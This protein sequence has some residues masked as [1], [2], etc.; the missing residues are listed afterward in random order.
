MARTASK[1][2]KASKNVKPKAPK[3]PKE[4][5]IKVHDP[6]KYNAGPAQNHFFH[7]QVFVVVSNET[8]ERYAKVTGAQPTTNRNNP[9]YRQGAEFAKRL[10]TP[11]YANEVLVLDI[12]RTAVVAD[13]DGGPA[14]NRVV[15][16]ITG[17]AH[18]VLASITNFMVYIKKHT[19]AGQDKSDEVLIR[20]SKAAALEMLRDP[21]ITVAKSYLDD[22][23][24][25]AQ[26]LEILNEYRK[27]AESYKERNIFPYD[28]EMLNSIRVS[29]KSSSELSK[30]DKKPKNKPAASSV[31]VEG[32]KKRGPVPLLAKIKNGLNADKTKAV[33]LVK[34]GVRVGADGKTKSVTWV[35]ADKTVVHPKLVVDG[36]TWIVS[37]DRDL[38]AFFEQ[39]ANENPEGSTNY[40]V[41]VRLTKA[42]QSAWDE[43]QRAHSVTVASTPAV[44]PAAV[45]VQ[46]VAPLVVHTPTPSKSP[47]VAAINTLITP[48]GG[49][50]SSLLGAA[51]PVSVTSESSFGG[52]MF[53]RGGDL[54]V[55][56]PATIVAPAQLPT[57]SAI[58]GILPVK[59]A[60]T[61][62]AQIQPLATPVAAQQ[63]LVPVQGLLN[64]NPSISNFFSAPV[65]PPT[66]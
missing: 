1:T 44:P 32:G 14:R 6:L 11:L 22:P 63:T 37:E 12:D 48:L 20:E 18:D 29:N 61:P 3:A 15:L 46:N 62:I 51:T 23:A 49:K 64:A 25:K 59:P 40:D 34:F 47:S 5:V 43:Y 42:L 57:V 58:P 27:N 17:D 56:K 45:V 50:V 52:G 24:L 19:S 9:N 7:G 55:Q 8:R 28:I 41:A 53:D 39:L 16:N 35:A 21:K 4:K 36:V 13:P 65:M 2:S 26:Q 10:E 54:P 60:L 66:M 30:K 33:S 38:Q 31:G